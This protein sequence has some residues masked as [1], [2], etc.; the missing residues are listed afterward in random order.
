MRVQDAFCYAKEKYEEIGVDVEKALDM[1]DKI[2]V[3]VHC[4]QL[5]DVSGFE[6]CGQLSGGIAATGNYPGKARDFSELKMD[7]KKALSYIPGKNKVNVHAIYQSDFISER[8]AIGPKNYAGWVEFAKE[9]KV[10]LDFNP[11]YF[12]HPKSD[13]GYTLSHKDEG[14]RQFW[15]EHGKKCREVAEYFGKSTGEVCVNNVWIPD[16]EKE[17]PVDGFLPRI[18]LKNSLDEIFKEDLGSHHINAVESKLFG[19]GSEAYVVGNHEF[20]MG[21]CMEN[22][23]IALTLDTGHFHPTEQVSA[24]ITSLLVYLDK[25]LLHV[26]RPIRWDSDHVV[27]FDD[28]TRNVFREIAKLD[29]FDKVMIATDYFDA[30]INRVLALAIGARN[31]KKALLK[32]LLLPVERLK[33]LENENDKT[34]R[35]LFLEELKTYPLGAVWEYYCYK[36]NCPIGQS[37]IDDA[38]SYEN[39]V[40]AKRV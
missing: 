29:A 2:P 17:V 21:Y 31:T 24:K 23:D 4:W 18:R 26:S 16:G 19:I 3:S 27:S 36:N 12:S 1:L 15:V 38:K 25:I 37:L 7:L 22:K 28:E 32:A 20:Y 35:L 14:I 40:L 11:T 10:G 33:E 9:E 8:N 6:K 34:L 39:E 13:D 5:D 30:S